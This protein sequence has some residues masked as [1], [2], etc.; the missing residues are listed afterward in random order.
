MFLNTKKICRIGSEPEGKPDS[1]Q[2]MISIKPQSGMVHKT[3]VK[4]DL[5]FLDWYL[6]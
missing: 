6:P 1:F 4:V 5:S 2:A 3:C